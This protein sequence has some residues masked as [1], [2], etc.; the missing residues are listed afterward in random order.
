MSAEIIQLFKT[1]TK[2]KCSFC[3]QEVKKAI[4]GQ[5]GKTICFSCVTLAAKRVEETK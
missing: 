1:E 2:Y 5:N 4:K 3:Q